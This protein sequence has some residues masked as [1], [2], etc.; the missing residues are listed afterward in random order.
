[1]EPAAG[2]LAQVSLVDEPNENG[3]RC[4]LRPP[5]ALVQDE[6][7]PLAPNNVYGVTKAAG[8]MTC[9]HYRDRYGLFA[10]AGILYNHE[11]ALRDP[12]FVS[13]KIIQGAIN[14]KKGRQDHLILGN[15]AA[16]V[17]WGYAP[18]YVE[19][20]HRIL[21]HSKAADFVISS[22]E[23]HSV[24]EFVKLVCGRLGLDWRSCIRE[25]RGVLTKP[26]ISLVGSPKKLMRLTG[27]KPSVD[28]KGLVERLCAAAAN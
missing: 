25:N 17:D 24:R 26:K 9:R 12:R 21:R 22:G 10:S 1:M 11:S 20:M 18:D 8:L 27:W 2:L 5:K 14:I 7:T 16:E 3:G 28:F 13:Q 19:A 6:T 4:E 15:L 23:K